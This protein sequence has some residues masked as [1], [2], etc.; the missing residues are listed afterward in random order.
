MTV[1]IGLGI[2]IAAVFISYLA[3]DGHLWALYQPTEI[4][5]ILGAAVG[6][7]VIATSRRSLRLL[8]LGLAGIFKRGIYDKAL[9]MDLMSCMYLILSSAKREGLRAVESH[10]ENPAESA[11]FSQYA[12][13]IKNKRVMEFLID[14]MRLMISG[15]MS[16]LELETLMDEELETVRETDALPVHAL[17]TMADGL[18]AFGIV[19]AVMGVIKALAAVDQPPSVL[20]ELISKALVGTFAGVLFAYGVGFPFADALERRNS[21]AIKAL[22]CVKVTLLAYV[23]GYPPQIAVE[24]G[25]KVLFNTVRPSFVELEEHVRS[26]RHSGAGAGAGAQSS[27]K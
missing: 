17:R 15:N 20:A 19:A 26:T 2:V 24:F 21:E 22:E 23:N 27:G 8:R 1:I 16:S 5:L 13:I 4:L 11:I 14:Y 18:P 12:N 7:L 10:I 25:R 6:A 3:G 9:Y